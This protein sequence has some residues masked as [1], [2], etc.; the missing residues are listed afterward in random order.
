MR[1]AD[2]IKRGRERKGET[3]DRKGHAHL[4]RRHAH[5][6]PHALCI[7]KPIVRYDAPR[8]R[9]LSPSC[10]RHHGRCRSMALLPT[11]SA[12]FRAP[13]VRSPTAAVVAS[14]AFRRYSTQLAMNLDD[15]LDEEAASAAAPPPL[16]ERATTA[17]ALPPALKLCLVDGHA[18]A[19][20]MNFAL[21]NTA[22]TTVGGEQTH[23]LYGFCTK[24]LDLS[25]RFAATGRSSRLTGRSPHSLRGAP[26][27]QGEPP[28]DADAAP[29]A[30]S[31]HHRG[32]RP[33]RRTAN[34]SA[35]L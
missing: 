27:L 24:L 26:E 10:H 11:L 7:G 30:A 21:Q 20:R 9:A 31:G 28:V 29:A 32:V 6:S 23:A 17:E 33:P 12:L 22:M 34:L 35:G 8:T 3:I 18:L 13:V 5:A 25:T 14:R 4:T 1:V 15:R 19:Y 16:V 2:K